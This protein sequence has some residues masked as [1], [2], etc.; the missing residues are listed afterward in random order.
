MKVYLIPY[1]K[2]DQAVSIGCMAAELL[3][4]YGA[5]VIFPEKLKG[6]AFDARVTYLPE[7]EAFKEADVVITVGG[8]GTILHAARAGVVYG[9]P[10][11]GINLGRT[12][13]LATCELEEIPTKLAAVAAGEY[14]LDQRMLL[15]AIVPNAPEMNFTALNDIVLYLGARKTTMDFTLFCDGIQINHYRGDGL[16]LST[17]TGSTAY[18]LSAGGP[19]LDASVGGI[20]AT[21]ICAHSLHSPPIVFNSE[22]RLSVQVHSAAKDEVYICSDGFN[23]KRLPPN[24]IVEVQRSY[25][26]VKLITFNPADQFKAIDE[27]LNGR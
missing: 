23:E 7:G 19:I 16:I 2:K 3:M 6:E 25:Q 17:P 22:R 26:T 1:E 18:S 4:S 8:D 11:L 27:K 12:G 20:I 14:K 10:I 5:E 15:S 13:F 21:P 9:K 24:C